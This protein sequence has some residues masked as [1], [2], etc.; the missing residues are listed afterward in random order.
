MFRRVKQTALCSLLEVCETSNPAP[1][2]VA[3]LADGKFPESSMFTWL[4]NGQWIA[5]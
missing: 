5:V 1:S 2:R 3:A 4:Q